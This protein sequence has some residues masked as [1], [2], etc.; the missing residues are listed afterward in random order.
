MVSPRRIFYGWFIVLGGF[1]IQVLNGGLLFHAFSAYILPLQ[2]EFGWSRTALSGAFSMAR[3]ESGILGPL[4]GWLIDR[5]GPRPSMLVGNL[6][7][8]IGFIL[9]SRMDSLPTF[10]LSFAIIAVGSSLGGFMPVATTVTNWFARQR[11]TALAITMAGMGVGG[12]LVPAVVWS[13]ST[14]GWRP[15]ALVSGLLVI[16]IGLPASLLMRHEP[17]PHGYLPDG[18][19]PETDPKAENAPSA[20]SRGRPTADP[21]FTARQALR[22]PAFWLLS[23]GHGAALLVVGTVLVHQIPHMVESIGLSEETAA[24]HVSLLVAISITGQLCGGYLGDRIDKRLAMFAC[25]WLHAAAL[26][27]FAFAT[28]RLEAVLFAVLHGI[29]WGV[30]G[31]LINAIRADYFGRAAYA[32][33]TGFNSLIVMIGMTCG[34]LFSG[35]LYDLAGDYK[36]AFLVLASLSALGSVAMFLAR[37]PT[38]PGRSRS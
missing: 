29:G 9:F 38:P 36:T 32:S 1:C 11:A 4:Q 25:M 21:G 6:L 18:A 3:A 34:P 8:G 12:L 15:T 35:F 19:R 14:Y 27:V 16:A 20:R 33:I 2:A 26:I 24:A 37:K 23:L 13:L 31:I 22:T 10:Y 7:F 28:T 5:F 17:E 30:R